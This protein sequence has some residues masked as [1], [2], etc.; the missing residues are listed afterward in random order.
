MEVN[1]KPYS[2]KVQDINVI[3]TNR[4]YRVETNLYLKQESCYCCREGGGGSSVLY[5]QLGGNRHSSK[6]GGN[7]HAWYAILLKVTSDLKR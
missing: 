7:R 6:K 2:L 5:D 4:E 3:F 1:L